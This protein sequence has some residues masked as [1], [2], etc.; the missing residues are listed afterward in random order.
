MIRNNIA[1]SLFIRLWCNKR[2]WARS[3]SVH[4]LQCLTWNFLPG[5]SVA[6]WHIFMP[7]IWNLAYFGGGWHKYVLFGIFWFDIFISFGIFW[8]GIFIS[9]GIFLSNQLFLTN[10]KC[11]TNF[12]PKFPT[13]LWV[14]TFFKLLSPLCVIFIKNRVAE[15]VIYHAAC[16][17]TKLKHVKLSMLNASLR[18]WHN[19]IVKQIFSIVK[20][21]KW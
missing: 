4:Y 20:T 14:E 1:W 18:V 19:F 21:W 6:N 15:D 9:F 12:F 3:V 11:W 16:V 17:N 13:L 2:F 7:N 10:A 8:F 5:H